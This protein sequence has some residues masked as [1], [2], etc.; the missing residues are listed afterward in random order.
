[1]WF[2][3]LQV[4]RLADDWQPDVADLQHRLE[5][6]AF[7]SCGAS[8]M[9]SLGWVPPRGNQGELLLTAQKHLLICL[10]IEQKLLPASVIRQHVQE[11]LAVIEERQGGKAGRRQKFE[12]REAV[13]AELLPR[14]FVRRRL[15]YA[16]IDPDPKRG[17]WLVIDAAS[18]AKADE[19]VEH[20]RLTLGHLPFR[21]LRT[22]ISPGTAMTDWL[23]AGEATG[24]FTID[25]DCELRAPG[26]ERAT[27]RYARHALEGDEIRRHIAAGK[28]ATRLALTWNDRISFL[29]T[30]QLQIKRLAF[31]D[32]LKE[33]V[34][35]AAEGADEVFEADFIIMAGEFSRLLPQI[36]EALGGEEAT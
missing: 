25:R 9:Q 14:A 29:L 7:R 3:N 11:R 15:T 1:M 31:L 27:V 4:Y 13:M 2:R 26:E 32:I 21:L 24:G 22:Q 30:D 5:R 8:E 23:A 17:G 16:W 34:E 35:R 20:L 18:P 6:N 36:V 12:T 19:M 10:G 28:L 33:E